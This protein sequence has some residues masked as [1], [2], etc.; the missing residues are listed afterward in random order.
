MWVGVGSWL[1]LG[2]AAA[3]GDSTEGSSSG[4]SGDGG[5]FDAGSTTPGA[6]AQADTGSTTDAGQDSG[7]DAGQDSGSDAGG[8]ITSCKTILAANAAAA[9]GMYTVDPDG[10]G[11]QGSVSV[12]CDMTNEGGG[13]TLGLLRNSVDTGS[14]P[15]F[16]SG[17][18][19]T[20]VL[21]TDPAV[22]SSTAAGTPAIAGWL[23]LNTFPYTEMV[24]EGWGA[25]ASKF[26]SAVIAKS[27]LRIPFGQNGYYLYDDANGYYWCGGAAGYTN[28]G[29][30]QVNQPVGAPTNCKGHSSL[31]DGWDFGGANA[32]ENLTA[33]GGGSALMKAGPAEA[34]VYYPTPGAAH[35]IWVR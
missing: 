35:A 31:G 17:Y 7:S 22:A 27:T 13:W 19:N 26:R 30:G 10:A 33:C 23:D 5:V 15:T 3:C 8:A 28:N 21:A 6:D 9:S 18:V 24:L 1:V 14:Y 32:N 20:A 2:V 25:G 34:Y 16:A 29:A 12:Y 11:P 4:S